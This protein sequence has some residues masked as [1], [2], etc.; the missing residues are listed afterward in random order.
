MMKHSIFTLLI[1]VLLLPS[2][3]QVYY[4]NPADHQPE[5]TRLA[6]YHGV[7]NLTSHTGEC[8][9]TTEMRTVD[10]DN[11]LDLGLFIHNQSDSTL[12]FDPKEVKAYGFDAKGKKGELK[13]FTATEY[14]EFAMV[15]EAFVNQLN[16]DSAIDL[17]GLASNNRVVPVHPTSVAPYIS[18]DG[19][20][21]AHSIAPHQGVAGMIKIGKNNAFKHNYLIEV[22]VNGRYV[23]FV[24]GKRVKVLP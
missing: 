3:G 16:F 17:A 12:H 21:R 14:V 20:L 11:F 4:Y 1:A 23:K 6:N 24:F 13:I 22:P 5:P 9:I 19:L 7:P 2:C 15:R 18:P 8:V 10:S